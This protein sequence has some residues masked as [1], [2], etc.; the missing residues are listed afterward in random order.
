MPPIHCGSL[1]TTMR[2][3]RID[4]WGSWLK[5][6]TRYKDP[7]LVYNTIS[8]DAFVDKPVFLLVA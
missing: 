8:S 2:R 7:Q 6:F 5:N 1:Q 4:G 3:C